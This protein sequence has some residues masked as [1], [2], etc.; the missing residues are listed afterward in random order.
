MIRDQ[1]RRW[2]A[3][4]QAVTGEQVPAIGGHGVVAGG[5][6]HVEVRAVEDDA[7]LVVTGASQGIK[8]RT[9]RGFIQ[10]DGRSGDLRWRRKVTGGK[11]RNHLFDGVTIDMPADDQLVRGEHF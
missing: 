1:D 2:Q 10:A 11:Y 8:Q 9:L 4:V 3:Q 6:R 5:F 7:R